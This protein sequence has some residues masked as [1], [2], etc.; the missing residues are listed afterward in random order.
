[1]RQVEDDT[2]D[3]RAIYLDARTDIKTRADLLAFI[4]AIHAE[5]QA[6][7]LGAAPRSIPTHLKTH[8]GNQ[9]SIQVLERGVWHSAQHARQLDFIAAGMGAE[10]KIPD[11]LYAGLPLPK[12]LWA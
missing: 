11:E 8:Y 4:E 2:I 10:L 6:T 3:A 9:S 12:R 1:M 7:W 5:Y